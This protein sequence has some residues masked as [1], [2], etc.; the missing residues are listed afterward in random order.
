MLE[1]GAGKGELA[2]ALRDGGYDV[3]AV[4]PSSEHEDVEPLAL[5]DLDRPPGSF[6]AAVSIVS[7]HHVEPLVESIRHL[8]TLVRPGGVLIVDEFDVARLDERAMRW[9]SA[10]QFARGEEVEDPSAVQ[11]DLVGHLHSVTALHEVLSEHFLIG[12]P[13]PGPYLHRWHLPPGLR[14]V[15][16]DLIGRGELPPTGAR[17]LGVRRDPAH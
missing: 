12:A 3:V 5:L 6:D 14:E 15:E 1:V 2:A 10:Q 7:L 4:D 16:I 9:W 11:A 8:A 17:M 13:I